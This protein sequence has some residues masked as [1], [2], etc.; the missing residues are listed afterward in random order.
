M[1]KAP[2]ER[3][4]II[5]LIQGS[6]D[7]RK[8]SNHCKPQT[9]DGSNATVTLGRLGTLGTLCPVFS[10]MVFLEYAPDSPQQVRILLLSNLGTWQ[11]HRRVFN[12]YSTSSAH[13]I[14]S[15]RG[16][17]MVLATMIGLGRS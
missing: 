7:E 13:G 9:R 14:L 5:L 11:K 1:P 10:K 17:N 6:G 8:D 4:V 16:M 12:G 2:A 3:K 15:S